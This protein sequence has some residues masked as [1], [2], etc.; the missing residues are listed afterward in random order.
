MLLFHGS[1]SYD[2][3]ISD[4]VLGVDHLSEKVL[5]IWLAAQRAVT[6][7]EGIL[8][9][10]GP[11]G[12]LIRKLLTWIGLIHS[13]PKRA[14]DYNT[15][16]TSSEAYLRFIFDITSLLFWPS[17]ESLFCLAKI[18]HTNTYTHIMRLSCQS[19]LINIFSSIFFNLF[20]YRSFKI[21]FHSCLMVELGG[22]WIGWNLDL[23]WSFI[24]MVK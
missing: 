9:S 14:P 10:V 20:P 4:D 7:Y 6:R 2:E 21:S 15:D 16:Y 22:C 17:Q 3:H 18:S 19:F 8:S 23:K 12:R 1:Y 13:S 11:R 5:P 24:Y